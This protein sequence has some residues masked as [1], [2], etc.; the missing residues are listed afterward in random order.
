MYKYIH[1]YIYIY[2]YYLVGTSSKL[3]KEMI[4]DLN[5]KYDLQIQL[6]SRQDLAYR[7]MVE[8]LPPRFL[9]GFTYGQ[10]PKP[11]RSQRIAVPPVETDV[12]FFNFFFFKFFVH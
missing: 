3:R 10:D 1:I 4:R 12:I 2:I 8:T 5:E 9:S 7:K 11:L 6:Y